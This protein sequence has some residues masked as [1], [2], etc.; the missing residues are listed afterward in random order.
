MRNMV[1]IL[2]LLLGLSV[3]A[4]AAELPTAGPEAQGF[5][6]VG[7]AEAVAGIDASGLPVHSLMLMRSGKIFLDATFYPYDG[8]SPHDLASVTKSVM[9]S[10]IAIAAGEGKLDLDAPMLSFFPG[11]EIANR[12]SRKEVI[13][14]RHLTQMTSGLACIGIPEEVTL[15]EM[16][17]S[18]DFV[19]F[20]LDLP[21]L[22]EPG[23]RF[24]YCS[25]GMHLLSAVLTAATDQTALDY[26]KEKLFAPLGVTDV[27]WDDDPQ[28]ISRGWG[29]LHL[30]PHDMA[31]LGMLWLAGGVWGGT[32]VIP[33]DWLKA[34]TTS[35]IT[36]DR[37]EDYGYGFWIG[38]ASEPIPYFM[39][40]GRGGQRIL[41]APSLELI[42]VTTGGGF[43]PGD[44][45]DP[46][47]AT[48]RDPANPLLANPAGEAALTAALSAINMPPEAQPVPAL[49]AMAAEVSGKAYSLPPNFGGLTAVRLDFPGG[50]EAI[51]T[52]TDA[53]GATPYAVGLDGVYRFSPGEKGMPVGSSG[54]WTGEDTF[55]LDYNTIGNIR[56]FT[57]TVLYAGD[58]LVMTIAQRDESMT[59][60][61]EG[62]A[63]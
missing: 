34:A 20:A 47:I 52:L 13:T 45:I 56:A 32:Q 42:I 2:A 33:A 43:D 36:A 31:R 54:G 46:V 6:S 23:T 57:I 19:Q 60:T 18:S 21:M 39:A 26:S 10:L 37:Y 35:A 9:T 51:L 49:P 17:V 22:A 55:V 7:L 4:T 29:D 59:L 44:I 11:R 41:V 5:D 27:R 61:L 14:V 15:A 25:P 63:E 58:G 50:D 24:D 30:L 28:G 40:S 62:K 38:P 48:L 16:E 1:P 3:P 53:Q 12:D 8:Q